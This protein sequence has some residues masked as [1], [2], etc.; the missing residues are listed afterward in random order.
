MVGDYKL[1]YDSLS[2]TIKKWDDFVRVFK[3]RYDNEFVRRDRCRILHSRRQRIH[4]PCEQF[5]LEMFNLSRQIDPTESDQVSLSR[6]RDALDPRLGG[7]IGNLNPWS[8]NNFLSR[9]KNVM[10]I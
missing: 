3:D 1:W 2:S 5:V 6:V 8:M 10:I 9:L 4:D 7:M